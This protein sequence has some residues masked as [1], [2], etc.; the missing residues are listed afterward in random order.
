MRWNTGTLFGGQNGKSGRMPLRAIEGDRDGRAK[1][2][3]PVSLQSLP[4]A[5]RKRCPMGTRWEKSHVRLEGPTKVYAR[6]A[7]SGFEIRYYFCPN[8][9]STIFAEGDRTPEFCAVPAGC[10]ADLS[11]PA[12]TISVWEES[13]HSWLAVAS[14][15][16]HH[17]RDRTLMR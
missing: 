14:V 11:L 2:R 1:Q 17:R 13:M 9:G 10:F 8:C 16:E 3:L 6:I 5:K 7:D 15:A 4:A 12:P